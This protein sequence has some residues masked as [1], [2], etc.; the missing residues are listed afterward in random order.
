MAHQWPAP[1]NTPQH[2]NEPP[3]LVEDYAGRKQR[4]HALGNILMPQVVYPIFKA[5]Y[6]RLSAEVMP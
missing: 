6:D 4:I 5:L 2:E 3:R 1:P